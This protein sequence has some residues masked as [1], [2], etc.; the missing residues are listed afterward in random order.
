MQDTRYTAEI[1]ILVSKDLSF[2]RS[3]GKEGVG[4]NKQLCRIYLGG[5]KYFIEE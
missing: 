3:K 4:Y 2:Q 1:K 5:S